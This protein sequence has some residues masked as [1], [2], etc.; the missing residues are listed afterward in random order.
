MNHAVH[1]RHSNANNCIDKTLFES[2]L[3]LFFNILSGNNMYSVKR[4]LSVK[5]LGEKCQAL[6]QP[7]KRLSNKDVAEKYGVPKNTISTWIKN[8]SRYFA[9]LEQSKKKTKIQ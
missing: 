2:L 8:Q 5:S 3:F 1:F 6:R 7:E 9:A 4:Q